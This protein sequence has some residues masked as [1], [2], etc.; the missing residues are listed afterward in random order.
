MIVGLVLSNLLYP[1]VAL[2]AAVILGF[3]V[4]A[5]YRKPKSIDANIKTFHRG[6]QALAPEDQDPAKA[7]PVPIQVRSVND[8]GA[9]AGNGSGPADSSERPKSHHGAAEHNGNGASH[10]TSGGASRATSRATEPA[11]AAGGYKPSSSSGGV[12]SPEPNSETETG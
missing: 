4:A 8:P 3:I 10:A 6:L 7:N 9:G 12:A 1:V 2:A 11:Q 5:R